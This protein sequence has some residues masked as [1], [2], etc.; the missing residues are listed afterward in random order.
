MVIILSYIHQ[1]IMLYTLNYYNLVC[2]SHLKIGEINRLLNNPTFMKRKK[3][4]I[5]VTLNL[6]YH[7][8]LN[9]PFLFTKKI[10]TK[11]CSQLN[12]NELQITGYIMISEM[13]KWHGYPQIGKMLH[14][15]F[16]FIHCKINALPTTSE[17]SVE[18]QFKSPLG[19][20]RW[21]GWILTPLQLQC[22]SSKREY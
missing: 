5:L 11:K 16:P 17:E 8:W 18:F 20:L 3:M 10:K 1:M 9:A 21:P 22:S 4:Y 14:C 13:L 15:R 19:S 7:W 12:H 2:Q 6:R